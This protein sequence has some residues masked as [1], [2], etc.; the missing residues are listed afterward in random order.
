MLIVASWRRAPH[1][2]RQTDSVAERLVIS[3]FTPDDEEELFA[4]YASVIQAGRSFPRRPPT[5]IGTFRAAWLEGMTSVQVGRFGGRVAGSYFLRPAF[6]DAAAHIANGGYL[7]ADELRGRG[8]GRSLA[9]H[10]LREAR[11]RGFDSMLFTLVLEGNPSRRLW[12]SLGFVEV[13]RVPHAVDGE[14]AYIYW[15]SLT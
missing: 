2:K 8:F 12:V 15:R 10:S 6:P 4:A 1:R 14:D 13:G 3:E 11:G 7:V 5:D 9:E